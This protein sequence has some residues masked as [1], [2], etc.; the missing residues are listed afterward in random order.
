MEG[1][2]MRCKANKEMKVGLIQK[3]KNGAFMAKGK[4][5]ECECNMAKIM[6]KDTATKVAQEHNI[7]LPE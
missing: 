7:Q 5:V 4:C 6:S 1:R 3:T 2:C